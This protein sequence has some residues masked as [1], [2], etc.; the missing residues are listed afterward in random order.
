MSRWGRASCHLLAALCAPG[1]R[2]KC[3]RQRPTCGVRCWLTRRPV[4]S[5][6][7]PMLTH[8]QVGKLLSNWRPVLITEDAQLA[9]ELQT[10]FDGPDGEAGDG[11]GKAAQGSQ[12][13]ADANGGDGDDDDDDDDGPVTCDELLTDMGLWHDYLEVLGLSG[14]CSTAWTHT[15][16]SGSTPDCS[17]DQQQQ[18]QGAA[19]RR[20]STF[21]SGIGLGGGGDGVSALGRGDGVSALGRGDGVLGLGRGDGVSALGR[22]D[23]VLA[24]GRAASTSSLDLGAG[25]AALY[26]TERYRAHMAG[27]AVS[28]LEFAVDKGWWV[29]ARGSLFV[30]WRS[31]RWSV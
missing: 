2:P 7:R 16:G 12:A 9:A 15:S 22:G 10:L 24:L 20:G 30:T 14:S 19:F 11:Q 26:G 18:Q 21:W 8:A 31:P 23:G 27:V 13:P 29:H 6:T 1:C 4:S 3:Q 28:L 17:L 25:L 5:F